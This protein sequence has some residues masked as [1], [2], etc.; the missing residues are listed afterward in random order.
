MLR[1]SNPRQGTDFRTTHHS[2]ITRTHHS[3]ITRT[4]HSYTSLHSTGDRLPY[5]D[6]GRYF[7]NRRLFVLVF[8]FG[9]FLPLSMLPSLNALRHVSL[10]ATVAMCYVVIVVLARLFLAVAE[11]GKSAHCAYFT[12]HTRILNVVVEDTGCGGHWLAVT[13][14]PPQRDWCKYQ[15]ERERER[16]RGGGEGERAVFLSSP[17]LASSYV[18]GCPLFLLTCALLMT[19]SRLEVRSAKLEIFQT[20][21]AQQAA[22]R[23]LPR[24]LILRL[25]FQRFRL[26]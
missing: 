1:Q 5:D 24:S 2:Y 11:E 25:P 26:R 3:F 12:V 4:H 6:D 15:R 16:E 14:L 23:L 13:V 17:V 21:C 8:G 18:D 9:V 22:H 7:D 10:A 19:S 20:V